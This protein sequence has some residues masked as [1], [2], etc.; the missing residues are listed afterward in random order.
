M[1]VHK[2]N[3]GAH[4]LSVIFRSVKGLNICI[5]IRYLSTVIRSFF[6][7]DS[8]LTGGYENVPTRD[9][10]MNQVEFEP[11]WL[12]FLKEY[13]RPL[14][15]LVFTGYYHDV[16]Y[17]FFN[18]CTH[19]F[20]GSTYRWWIRSRTNTRYTYETSWPPWILVKVSLRIRWPLART[21]FFRL[22]YK[23]KVYPET[24]LLGRRNGILLVAQDVCTVRF[25]NV[26]SIAPRPTW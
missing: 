4:T 2:D 15:E 11:Q 7:Q 13:V 17:I 21:C 24:T 8:R 9:I 18:A 26:F 3:H 19:H 16:S 1:I 5:L 22:Q 12:N 20:L 25:I 10:H 14:Q 6:S 23:R